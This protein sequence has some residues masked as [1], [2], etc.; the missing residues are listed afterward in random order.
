MSI[1]RKSLTLSLLSLFAFANA[2]SYNL[3]DTAVLDSFEP[4]YGDALHQNYVGAIY[5]LVT[6]SASFEGEGYWYTYED[7]DGAVIRNSLGDVVTE[8]TTESMINEDE[9][10]LHVVFDVSES[11]NDHPFAGIGTNLVGEG[12]QYFDF[13]NLTSVN[14]RVKGSGTVRLRM[15]T[16]DVNDI[17]DWGYYGY[18][19]TL[20]D[21]WATIEVTSDMLEAALWSETAGDPDMTWSSGR[22]HVNKISFQSEDAELFIDE[23]VFEGM[24]YSDFDFETTS[25]QRVVRNAASNSSFSFANSVLT[26]NGPV[27]E[28]TSLSIY[29]LRGNLISNTFSI[30]SGRAV[31]SPQNQNIV[32]G[33]YIAVLSDN[34]KVVK[35][36]F[37]IVK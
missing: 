24:T 35:Q 20:S 33:R 23:I 2:Q 22:T 16:K 4:L 10:H 5:G 17:G 37:N 32:N 6:E 21:E 34:N 7:G 29:D 11:D 13:T 36:Q 12:T 1:F 8:T 30:N 25:A 15:E 19:I 3:D 18:D 31:W 28:N 14:L 9:N 26:Y 27:S